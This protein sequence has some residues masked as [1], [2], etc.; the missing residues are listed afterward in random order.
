MRGENFFI[1][2]LGEGGIRKIDGPISEVE[3]YEK[4]RREEW[5]KEEPIWPHIRS[6]FSRDQGEALEEFLIELYGGRGEEL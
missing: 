2:W 5:Y 1:F 6:S 3:A 4:A